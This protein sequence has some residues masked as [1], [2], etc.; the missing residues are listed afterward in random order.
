MNLARKRVGTAHPAALYVAAGLLFPLQ[1]AAQEVSPLSPRH[2]SV[3]FGDSFD[4][5]DSGRVWSVTSPDD[6]SWTGDAFAASGFRSRA[7][8]MVAK[9][10]PYETFQEHEVFLELSQ[11][12]NS[13]FTY[14][15]SSSDGISLSLELDST[16]A[17]APSIHV[18]QEGFLANA[19]MRY[20]YVS[21]WMGTLGAM[22]L[23]ADELGFVVRDSATHEDVFSGQLTLRRAVDS[24]EPEDVYGQDYTF[25][26]VYQADLADLNEPGAYYLDLSG[27]GRSYEFEI[28]AGVYD[29]AF[30]TTFRALYHQR[31]G[32]AL[33]SEYTQWT[34]GECHHDPVHLTTND[35]NVSGADAFSALPGAATGE[36][37][38]AIGGYHDAGDYDRRIS[39]LVVVDELVDLY[40]MDPERFA[41]DSAGIP[42]SGNGLPDLL[43][44]ALWAMGLYRQM[45]RSDGAVSAGVETTGYSDWGVMP[46]DDQNPDGS[47]WV[48][49]AY[50]FEPSSTMRF[51]SA[52]AK[53]SRVLEDHDEEQAAQLLSE[54]A[55]AWDWAYPRG[56]RDTWSDSRVHV[57]EVQAA[58]AA[59]ELL[60]TTGEAGYH[61]AFVALGPFADGNLAF[62]L[63]DWDAFVWMEAFYAYAQADAAD[64]EYAAAAE[65]VFVERS[66]A[67]LRAAE[68][69]AFRLVKHP[70]GPVRQ[71]GASTPT[72]EGPG[73]LLR[74]WRLTGRVEFKDGAVSTCDM[75][76]G[77]NPTGRSWVTGVGDNPVME[78]LHH[79][80]IGDGIDAPVPG[81]T[82]YGPHD[83]IESGGIL[84]AALSAYQ[85]EVSQWPQ[86]ERYAD[87]GYPPPTN[88]FT[89]QESIGP[90]LF[91]FGVLAELAT[92]GGEGEPDEPDQ[93]DQQDQEEKSSSCRC[94]SDG[95]S[96][97]FGLV[98]VTGLALL[99]ARRRQ[100]HGLPRG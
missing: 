24:S 76:L 46:E 82:V 42:E 3:M 15:L 72:R 1:A 49:Y 98:M 94:S 66:E 80:S 52:A 58:Q 8:D 18:N 55:A 22:E 93:P 35:Y 75:T 26:N 6:P 4:P 67:L 73:V 54:A 57:Y 85:P 37:I 83:A 7:S 51:A 97:G 95:S 10:W 27:V 96:G 50:D 99:G 63:Q 32:T 21:S 77:G 60:A 41:W 65:R 45:Q 17:L 43:D 11:P 39:H 71:S 9:G 91:A 19:N 25:T 79:P 78:P 89:V 30:K 70:Y 64:P 40:E 47:P 84:G 14:E 56:P 12:M 53:L 28:G 33:T 23:G 44:E 100:V 90:T 81:I 16:A 20:A 61:D 5:A 68:P 13:G 92:D 34:H 59:A 62:S 74:A 87:V 48:W 69:S 38:E 31:C 2:L 86:L 36:T 88:E 29:Q